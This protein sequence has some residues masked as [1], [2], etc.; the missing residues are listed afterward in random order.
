MILP[1]PTTP[2]PVHASA[3]IQARGSLTVAPAMFHGSFGSRRSKRT[4]RS[5]TAR[6]QDP[7]GPRGAYGRRACRSYEGARCQPA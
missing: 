2:T 7:R 1:S 4:V 5:P 6:T 3:R